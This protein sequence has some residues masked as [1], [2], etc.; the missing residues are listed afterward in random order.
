MPPAKSRAEIGLTDEPPVIGS[1][2]EAPPITREG[3]FVLQGHGQHW[4][5]IG[6]GDRK[7]SHGPS[8][9]VIV[10]REAAVALMHSAGY[11]PATR[12]QVLGE[13]EVL[14]VRISALQQ[15]LQ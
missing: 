9:L 7:F 14:Q 5:D 2:D 12:E 6:H 4:D 10:P 11:A 15:H 8:G 13:I 1:V 3:L